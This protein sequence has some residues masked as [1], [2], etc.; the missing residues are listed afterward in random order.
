MVS[1]L[2]QHNGLQLAD[3]IPSLMEMLNMNSAALKSLSINSLI[4]VGYHVLEEASVHHNDTNE[5]ISRLVALLLNSVENENKEKTAMRDKFLFAVWC[6][7]GET[8][9]TSHVS[10]HQMY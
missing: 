5:Y 7:T 9:Y 1:C 10:L 2:E 4:Q 8:I 6:K 3:A